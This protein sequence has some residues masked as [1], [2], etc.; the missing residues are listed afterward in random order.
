MY[1]IMIKLQLTTVS[2]FYNTC[3]RNRD[4]YYYL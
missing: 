2:S 1:I 4:E 3:L